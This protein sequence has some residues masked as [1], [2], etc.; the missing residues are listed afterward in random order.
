A[1]RVPVGRQPARCLPG[2]ARGE[3]HLERVAD[4]AGRPGAPAARRHLALR[5][6]RLA[7]GIPRRARRVTRADP[8]TRVR[9]GGLAL[10]AALLVALVGLAGWHATQGTTDLGLAELLGWLRG[11][12]GHAAVIVE[13]R[14]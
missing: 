13:S 9:P 11:E 10:G 8:V 1:H 3:R 6:R 4:R 7:D 5:R 12:D 14:L 2:P